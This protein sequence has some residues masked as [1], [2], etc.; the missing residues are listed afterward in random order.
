MILLLANIVLKVLKRVISKSLQRREGKYVKLSEQRSQTLISLLHSVV[1][2]IIYFVA[3]LLV[4]DELGFSLTSVLVGAGVLGL[5]VGFG[6][7]N[8]VRD[9]ITGFFLFF[10]KISFPLETL[11]QQEIIPAQ[12]LNLDC[13]LRRY[14]I[15]PGK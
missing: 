14:R 4:L 12:S 11:L 9:V 5:A 2:N 1:A 10:M 7:Q 15:G 13:A 8:V 3:I 6:A